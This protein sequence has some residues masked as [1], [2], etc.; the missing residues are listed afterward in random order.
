M[1][2]FRHI[3]VLALLGASSFQAW[4]WVD[5]VPIQRPLPGAAPV[6]AKQLFNIIPNNTTAIPAL[7]LNHRSKSEHFSLND[8]SLYFGKL[9]G[10]DAQKGFLWKHPYI[11]PD[12]RVSPSHVK[13]IQLGQRETPANS[14]NHNCQITL[15]NG[16]ALSGELKSLS[17]GKLTL[18][19]W[20]GGELQLKQSALKTLVPG[21]TALKDLYQGP[22]SVR[23]WTF[24]DSSNGQY[25]KALAADATAE[26]VEK[27]NKKLNLSN[28]AWKLKDQTFEARRSQA[29]V[30]R[31]FENLPN[32]LRYD[33][34][35]HW[36][37]YLN[38]YVNFLTDNLNSYSSGN[39]YCLR[40]NTSY[41]YLYR[42]KLK[43]GA[44]NGR[45]VGSNVRINLNTL[46]NHA[47]FSIRVDRKKNS[48][49]LF[50]NEKFIKHWD[51]AQNDP[52]PIESKGLMFTSMSSNPV[53]LSQIS[54]AEWN[55]KIP[56]GNNVTEQQSDQDFILFANEDS[57]SGKL[58]GIA[59]GNMT[60][61]T[62]FAKLP[63]PLKNITR[64]NLA[65]SKPE[66][67]SPRTVRAVMRNG[68]GSVSG[69]LLKWEDGKIS[70]KS[71]YFGEA[72]FVESIFQSIEFG[73]KPLET[74]RRQPTTTGLK[75]LPVRQQ[76]RKIPRIEELQQLE[77]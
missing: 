38:L 59:E 20:Y 11:T 75:P 32:S 13:Y 34:N 64:V 76:L 58:I 37:G 65:K 44:G 28:G 30:G 56:G 69:E 68:Q 60:F 71:P 15:A 43:N 10:F 19:T 42:Y 36:T 72:S 25:L 54:L 2:R 12:L 50:I 18:S 21:F 7:K 57:M 33:F 77:R 51:D 46:G 41:A 61:E 52:L 45:N 23:D 31:N 49:A 74:S 35:V 6:L 40:I 3:L 27:K 66:P 62:P 8:G 9:A 63:I 39:A 14:Q 1:N 26:E 5:A 73:A 48:I 67:L 22:Q 53:T 17:E 70:L 24:Y 4:G 16:D 55:G 29:R 47:R